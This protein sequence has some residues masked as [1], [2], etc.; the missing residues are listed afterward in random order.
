MENQKDKKI[1]THNNELL[2]NKI[3]NKS[4]LII[5]IIS[6]IILICLLF[7]ITISF[8]ISKYSEPNIYIKT[9]NESHFFIKYIV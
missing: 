4:R 6:T 2:D 1:Y 9:S 3:T 8:I 7:I 5:N